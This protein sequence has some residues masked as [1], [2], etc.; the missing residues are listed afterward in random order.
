M[1]QQNKEDTNS[2]GSWELLSSLVS[3]HHCQQK[4]IYVTLIMFI[5]IC[6]HPS[7]LS[8][9]LLGVIATG[10]QMTCIFILNK[11]PALCGVEHC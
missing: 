2:L 7:S 8:E 5:F 4:S 1:V 10:D 9:S 3:N 6:Q 11:I